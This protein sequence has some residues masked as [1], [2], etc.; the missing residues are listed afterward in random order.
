[1]TPASIR[2]R[3]RTD[4][5]PP[6]RPNQATQINT[7]ARLIGE[8]A[9]EL[10]VPLASLRNFIQSLH[11]GELGSVTGG[12]R[13]LLESAITRCDDLE[14]M[15]GKILR[16]EQPQWAV[17][18]V[19]RR[20]V[21][22]ANIRQAVDHALQEQGL[23]AAVDILWDL[24]DA[25]ELAVFADP[26][27]LE[28]MIV[29]LVKQSI[30][31]TSA[32]GCVL[33]RLRTSDDVVRWSIIDQ[34]PG[35]CQRDIELQ[36]QQEIDGVDSELVTHQQ[37]ASLHFS[38]LEI[39]SRIGRGKEVSFDTPRSGPRS[40]AA[41]WSRWRT[42]QRA[43]PDAEQANDSVI[44]LDSKRRLRFDSALT[45]VSLPR[46][47]QQ[48]R[49]AD[50]LWAGTVMLGGAVSRSSA[51][52]FDGFL[53]R[54]LRMLDLAYRVGTRR[55]VWAFDGDLAEAGTRI[56]SMI[57]G[58]SSLGSGIRMRWSQPRSIPIDDH[59]TNLRLSE[60]LVR[61]VLAES[62]SRGMVDQNTVRMGTAPIEPSATIAVRLNEE[63]QRLS[64]QLKS[65]TQRLKRQSKS[66]RQL[67]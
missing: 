29:Q 48:P 49:S 59:Q 46:Y 39:Y 13:V 61:E 9:D 45:R 36:L 28:R 47:R 41:V 33:I 37:I 56:D 14:R 15:I 67:S 57:S 17:P 5:A 66:L 31:A 24:A 23:P 27:L 4:S 42:A 30:R 16:I 64:N 1:M 38:A 10:R 65:Q 12:Q 53:Q 54:Q 51:D 34:G 21:T 58:A 43:A 62:R 35:V 63:L 19:Q 50:S 25:A 44:E 22:V 2:Q 18:H 32:G 60:L 6:V 8:V 40:V 55:W 20:R 11:N 3:N 52:A 26:I 7:A